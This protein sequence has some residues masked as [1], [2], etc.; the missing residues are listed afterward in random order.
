MKFSNIFSFIALLFI[1]GC[2]VKAANP[3]IEVLSPTEFRTELT[4]NANAYLLDVRR[5]DEFAA[6]HLQGAHLLNWLDSEKFKKEARLID[7]TKTVYIYCR[8]G[9]RSNE[10]ANYLSSQGYK[11]IDMDG[12][13]IAWEKDG[14]PVTTDTNNSDR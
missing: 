14:M 4:E 12:G 8:S 11:V 9:R 5:P 13:I 10:A 6:G 3:N 1:S 7:K 2:S